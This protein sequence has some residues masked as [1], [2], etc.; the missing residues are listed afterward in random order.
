MHLLDR[1]KKINS[2]QIAGTDSI[3]ILRTKEEELNNCTFCKIAL[4]LLVVLYHSL[5]FWN[6]DWFTVVPVRKDPV[7]T[8]FAAWLNSFHIYGF[9]LISGYIFSALREKGKYNQYLPFVVGKVKRLLVPYVFTALVWVIPISTAFFRFTGSEIIEKYVFAIAP[10][11]LWFLWM[12]F[13][14]FLISWPIY[15]LYKAKPVLCVLLVLLLYAVRAVGITFIRN[16]FCI[17]TALAHL[18][19][20]LLGIMLQ[21]RRSSSLDSVPLLG[22]LV[23]HGALFAINAFLHNSDQILMKAVSFGCSFLLHIFGAL[24]A[25]FILQRLASFMQSKLKYGTHFIKGKYLFPIYLFH[26]Q[27][28]YVTIWLL[29]GK[30]NQY[31][32][33]ALNFIMSLCVS[34]LISKLL[35]HWKTTSILIGV[36]GN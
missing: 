4:M 7:F 10:S 18:P 27:V 22:W 14:V 36:K 16:Y 11:Q 2:P 15:K 28:I 17:W 5:L 3:S 12:L 25:F 35:M 24:M 32:L 19:L 33:L 26:Q 21:N 8:A 31:V 13:W 34:I 9:T 29:A 6:G 30:T 23:I 20:F 1:F